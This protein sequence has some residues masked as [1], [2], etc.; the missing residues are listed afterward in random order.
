M[1]LIGYARVSSTGQELALQE[2]AL[3]KAGAERIFSEKVTGTLRDRPQLAAALDYLRPGDTLVVYSLS[4]LG[5][6]LS[7]LIDTVNG[8]EARGIGFKSVVETID[9]STPSGR[10]T[11]HLFAS[12]SE[13]VREMIREGAAAGR[14][15]AKAR[16]QTGAD[17]PL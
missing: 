2:D 14:A 10:F 4:R 16:G 11:F 15:A 3:T 12:L 8:L 6:S 9:T 17:P 1:A 13:F 5:R 7:H